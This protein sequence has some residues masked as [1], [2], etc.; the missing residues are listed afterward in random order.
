MN[1]YIFITTEGYTF[2]QGSEASEPDIENCQV[3]GFAK[4][5]NERQAFDN[6]IEENSYLLDT[7]FDEIQCFELK[8]NTP[9]HYFYVTEWQ[10]K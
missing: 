1:S 5:F 8:D 2:Q 3:V 7:T 6:M 9:R 10:N 4:G